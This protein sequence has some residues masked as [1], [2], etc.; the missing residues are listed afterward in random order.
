MFAIGQLRNLVEFFGPS[1]VLMGTDYPFDMGEYD[2][3]GHVV[4]SLGDAMVAGK[5]CGGNA[6]AVLGL[7]P[8]G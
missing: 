8:Q 1:H 3:I 5:I 4:D 7:S 6:M 2:P